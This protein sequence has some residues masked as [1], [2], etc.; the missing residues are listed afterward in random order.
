MTHSDT[1]NTRWIRELS[2]MQRRA[3]GRRELRQ[4]HT[5]AGDVHGRKS[6]SGSLSKVSTAA[7]AVGNGVVMGGL[8]GSV[9]G[10][11]SGVA[12]GALIA[13]LGYLWVA[14]SESNKSDRHD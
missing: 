14:A 12:A 11:T 4:F 10:A 13:L 6:S 8:L 5:S 1:V 9:F 2:R 3:D 7:L